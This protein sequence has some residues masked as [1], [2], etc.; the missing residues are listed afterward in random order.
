[1]GKLIKKSIL[2]GLLIGIAACM[3]MA[4]INKYVGSLL[5][6]IGLIAVL[7]LEANLFTGKIGYVN[8]YQKLK[9]AVIILVFNLLTAFLIGLAYKYCISDTNAVVDRFYNYVWYKVLFKGFGTG[10]LIYLGVELYKKSNNF[11]PV[12]L[13]IMGFILAGFSHC[14][15]DA[16]Y[17][18]I[19]GLSLEG[20]GYIGLVIIGNS[21]GS[22]LIRFLQIEISKNIE[23]KN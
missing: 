2:A 12:V 4:C 15:A 23:V 3:Y 13:S 9:E 21:I 5:F 1:M 18:A 6:S 8:S 10:I 22:L 19:A 11:I 20:L 14:V 7:L 17:I 16:C